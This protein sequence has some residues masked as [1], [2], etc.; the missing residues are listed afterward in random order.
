MAAWLLL[1]FFICLHNQLSSMHSILK[2]LHIKEYRRLKKVIH[3][4]DRKKEW[5]LLSAS[6][7][8][9]FGLV[10]A[11]TLEN[12]FSW[13]FLCSYSVSSSWLAIVDCVCIL[14]V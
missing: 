3:Q 8:T 4:I 10:F 12:A 6:F 5:L 2:I 1:T 13:R 11:L 14:H 7:T 9:K